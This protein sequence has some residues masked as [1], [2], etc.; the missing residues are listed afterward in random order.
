[1]VETRSGSI[2]CEQSVGEIR[3]NGLVFVVGHMTNVR[4]FK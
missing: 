4:W 3:A 2:D 1:M